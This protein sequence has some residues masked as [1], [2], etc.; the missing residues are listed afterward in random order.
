MLFQEVIDNRNLLQN[1][2]SGL[3]YSLSE[4]KLPSIR[5]LWF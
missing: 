1:Q 2:I 4:R 3:L 5:R